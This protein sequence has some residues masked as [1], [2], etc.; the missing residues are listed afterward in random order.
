M[1]EQK[2]L[3]GVQ[4]V[5]VVTMG[6]R[7]WETCPQILTVTYVIAFVYFEQLDL[8]SPDLIYLYNKWE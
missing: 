4:E 7:A 5:K 3:Q 6:F 8:N 1:E 2:A